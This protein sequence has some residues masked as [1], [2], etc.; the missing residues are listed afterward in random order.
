MFKSCPE[1]FE[2]V[3]VSLKACP[4]CFH[5]WSNVEQDIIDNAP[6]EDW[7]SFCNGEYYKDGEFGVH[8]HNGNHWDINSDGNLGAN[9][10]LRED[11]EF[12]AN[13]KA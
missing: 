3:Q 5:V 7:E 4:Y 12:I 6:C 13:A 10:R 11:I 9:G 8:F 2:A 1:C